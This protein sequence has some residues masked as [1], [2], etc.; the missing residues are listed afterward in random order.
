MEEVLITIT[1]KTTGE[2]YLSRSYPHDDK[3]GNGKVELYST[4]VFKILI[5][6]SQGSFEHTGLRFM[7]FWNDP[8]NP[9]LGYKGRGWKNSGLADHH[10]KQAVPN[11]LPDY[12]VHNRPSPDKGAFQLHGNFLIHAGPR[13]LADKGWGA[14]GCVEII[15]FFEVFKQDVRALSGQ[16]ETALD[17]ALHG[18]VK[19][20]K[21]F[22][23]IQKTTRPR[24]QDRQKGEIELQ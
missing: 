12:S 17:T 10:S 19:A 20:Q 18:L 5:E 2:E 6:S 15:G 3:D 11:Y 22:F 23:E 14:A 7:P 8:A 24:L 13:T 21:L 4:P 9:D 1:S 16:H